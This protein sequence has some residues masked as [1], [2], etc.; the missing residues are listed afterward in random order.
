MPEDQ[1]DI[2]LTDDIVLVSHVLTNNG[3]VIIQVDRPV[4]ESCHDLL[5]SL[6]TRLL[7]PL[8]PILMARPKPG[9]ISYMCYL[10]D[11]IAD[12]SSLVN[13]LICYRAITT[14][15]TTSY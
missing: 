8:A 2:F 13:V 9:V 5:R 12:E 15:V 14:L 3:S 1:L 10:S 11:H 7:L 4:L 6:V